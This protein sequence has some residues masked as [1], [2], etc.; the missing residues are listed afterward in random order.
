MWFVTEHFMFNLSFPFQMEFTAMEGSMLEISIQEEEVEDR[1]EAQP[2]DEISLLEELMTTVGLPTTST[3]RKAIPS[4][5][6][7]TGAVDAG[8]DQSNAAE[9]RDTESHQPAAASV[10]VNHGL[11]QCTMCPYNTKKIFNYRRHVSTHRQK[12][13]HICHRCDAKFPTHIDLAAH[14]RD[15]K[16][17][18]IFYCDRCSKKF[19]SKQGLQGHVMSIHQNSG[20]FK[21]GQCDKTFPC[22]LNYSGHMNAVHLKYSPFQCKMC[23]KQFSYKQSFSRHEKTCSRQKSFSC[24]YCD[25]TFS[26]QRNANEH[27]EAKHRG[28]VHICHCGKIFAWRKNL[29]RHKKNCHNDWSFSGSGVYQEWGK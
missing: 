28:V 14:K 6:V 29:H 24:E 17:S 26:C 21:C 3:P 25:S 11:H 7:D 13:E 10:G 22:K 2:D 15:C 8:L 16:S 18:P 4:V 23:K 20:P 5:A 19:T 27:I 9:V 12:D 1:V